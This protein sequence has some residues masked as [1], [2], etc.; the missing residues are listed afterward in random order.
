MTETSEAAAVVDRG[1]A[2]AL[3]HQTTGT[4]PGTLMDE[5][6]TIRGAA[7]EAG[8]DEVAMVLGMVVEDVDAAPQGQILHPRDPSAAAEVGAGANLSMVTARIDVLVT[9]KNEGEAV[10]VIP[11]PQA[12]VEA[13]QHTRGDDIPPPKAVPLHAEEGTLPHHDLTQAPEAQAGVGAGA[14]A[15]AEDG[16]RRLEMAAEG[17]RLPGVGNAAVA[18]RLTAVHQDEAAT[19]PTEAARTT[20]TGHAGETAHRSHRAHQFVANL[21][22]FRKMHANPRSTPKRKQH[23]RQKSPRRMRSPRSVHPEGRETRGWECCEETLALAIT[24]RRARLVDA[25]DSTARQSTQG[26][27]ITTKDCQDEILRRWK[28][29]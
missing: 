22:M 7:Q 28:Y 19:G 16:T 24:N 3:D 17:H 1:E 13:R 21:L 15:A 6:A 2:I 18:S 4:S 12:Q 23:P 8:G 5:T 27:I 25:L 9:A 14:A 11:D 10:G 20:E 26:A 29:C